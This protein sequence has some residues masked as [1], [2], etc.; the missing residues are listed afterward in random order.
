MF[1][2]LLSEEASATWFPLEFGTPFD[3]A[4]AVLFWIAAAYIVVAVI[5]LIA[6]RGEKR[7]PL[8]RVGGIVTVALAAA[9]CLAFLIIAFIEDGIL[10]ILFYPLLVLIVVLA[11]SGLVL[12]FNRSKG[13]CIALGCLSAAALI[14]TFVCMGIHY[15][16]GGALENNGLTA[17]D[18]N[19]VALYVSA[20][21]LIAV[22]IV[23]AIVAGRKDRKG[24]DTRSITFAAVCVAMS[25]ALSYLKIV[26][27]PQGG[28]ITIASLLPLMIYSYMFGTKK[29][30]L[31]GFIY[32]VL[33]AFQDT[34]ILHPAQFLLDYPVAFSA[35]GLAGMF[36]K[37]D[38]LRFPQVKFLLG[39]L[40]ATAGRFLSH[41][42]SGIFAFG[43]FATIQPV[44]LYSLVYQAGYLLPD[45]AIAIVLGVIVFSSKAFL[46]VVNRY[47][48]PAAPKQA[49]KQ[50]GKA[51]AENK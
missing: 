49:E 12:F 1:F 19:T 45:I 41:F 29:G 32:G 10:P 18:V 11:A 5:L 31:A 24:F 6:V 33:Q 4:R 38:A 21:L 27:M 30:V 35:I 2:N 25:F 47:A 50:K 22:I 16:D 9:F 13:V 8:L 26:E 39:A 34:Y 43:E 37:V 51:A 36:A 48:A 14:A 46:S 44:W 23:A 7:K 15:A 42:L 3:A 28:S 40:V 17:E 20:V